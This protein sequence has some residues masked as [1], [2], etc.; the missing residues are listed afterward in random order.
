VLEDCRSIECLVAPTIV[1]MAFNM[2]L[3]SLGAY[4]V[5]FHAVSET[6]CPS[7]GMVYG[8]LENKSR[9]WTYDITDLNPSTVMCKLRKR[10]EEIIINSGWLSLV[11]MKNETMN[12][13]FS[14]NLELIN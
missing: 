12:L 5:T 8:I 13:Q 10:M 6:G 4:L 14:V 9:N 7:K 3:V 2:L 11:R 1:W